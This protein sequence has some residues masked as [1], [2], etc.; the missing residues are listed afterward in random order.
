[1]PQEIETDFIQE[2]KELLNSARERTKTA[3]NIAM[4]Y[5]YYE[6]GRRILKQEQKGLNRAEYGKKILKQL[7]SAL[8]KEFGKG[9]SISNL[10]TIRQFFVVYSQDRIGQ[11][12]FSQSQNLPTTLE[13]FPVWTKYW[14]PIIF[15]KRFSK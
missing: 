9:Y 3:I 1:M 12:A 6:I 5:T 2:V 15:D 13:G 10:K 7:S 14:P 8:T 11:T 4:V